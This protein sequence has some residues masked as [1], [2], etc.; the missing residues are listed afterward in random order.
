MSQ[1]EFLKPLKTWSHLAARRRKPSEYEIVTTNL[2]YTTNNPEAPFE[3]DPN[4][5][6]AQWFK[7]YRNSSALSH[8]DWN[9]FRD[10][11]E[12]VYRTYNLLQDGQETYV[13]GL[14]DQFSARGHDAM[15]ERTWAGTLVRLYTPARFLFHALQMGSAYLAQ[16][17][18]AST[19][20]N[21]AAYQTADSLRWLTHTAYRTRELSRTFTDLGFGR[22]ERHYWEQDPAWQGWRRVVEQALVAWDWAES[23]FALNLVVRPAMEE[24]VLRGLGQ[25]ARHNG[26]M[27]LGLLTDSQLADAQRHR[28]WAAK[29]VG[30]ALQQESNGSAFA[31]WL[32][33]WEP[34]AD[35]AVAAYCAALPDAPEA[36]ASAIAATRDFRLTIGL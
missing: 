15:L 28:R 30:M 12:M 7:R 16:M 35:E 29:L 32:N 27:L 31:T 22:D 6:M 8:P 1:P 23:F 17:A 26:D 21:C 9:A 14:L 10:P 11:D 2:H 20:S 25:A 13:S 19:I 18:P 34:L 3:L 4:F 5:G 24:T 33:K 36:Q